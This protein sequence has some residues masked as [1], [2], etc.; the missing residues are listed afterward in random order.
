[1]HHAPLLRQTDVDCVQHEGSL[2]QES[3]RMQ[4]Y[5]FR[6]AF[7]LTVRIC[8]AAEQSCGRSGHAATL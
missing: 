5:Q 8:E 3:E 4:D 1:M 2:L 6:P 7:H